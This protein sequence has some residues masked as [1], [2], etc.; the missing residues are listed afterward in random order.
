[1]TRLRCVTILALWVLVGWAAPANANAVAEWNAQA[2]QCISVGFAGTPTAP[3]IAATRVGP[4]GLLDL[5]IVHLAMHDAVQAIEKEYQPYKAEPPATGRESVAAA[6]AAAAYRVLSTICPDYKTLLDAAFKPYL[7]GGNPGLGVGYAAGDVLLEEYRPL[8]PTAHTPGTEPGDWQPTPP[9]NAPFNFLFLATTKPFTLDDPSQFR[10]PPHPPMNS[11]AYLRDFNEVKRTGSM[12]SHPELGA[13]PAPRRTDLARFWSGN[14]V[15][16]WN[17][18]VRLIALDH[19]LSIGE[20]ARLL[21]LANLAGADAAI[22]VWDS[23]LHYHFWRPITAIREA[24]TDPNPLTVPDPV[25][26]PFIQ[27]PHFAAGSQTPPY[28]DY[29]SGANGQTGAV[30]A[31]L[32]LF[33]RTDELDFEVYKATPAVVPI[34]TNPRVFRRL[35]DAAQEVV[36]ARILLGIHFRFADEEARKQGQRVALWAFSKYLRPVHDRR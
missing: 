14:F 1:M 7:A 32:Q 18:A 16:Q 9:G 22:T 31:M 26:T 19:Q 4:P 6:A 28:P 25:W 5:A 8:F 17:D 20:T 21:A 23:K 35:S 33:F 27:S 13:C 3:A 11:L 29:T 36:D 12:E 15:A 30:T 24:H 2:V 10:A 34:C